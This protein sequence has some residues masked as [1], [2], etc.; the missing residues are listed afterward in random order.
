ML[1]WSP[2]IGASF[3]WFSFCFAVGGLQA[4]HLLPRHVLDMLDFIINDNN[5][6]PVFAQN[7]LT[8]IDITFVKE[9]IFGPLH[10]GSDKEGA[11]PYLGRGP[12]KFFLYEI[13]AN[14]ISQ[15]R[16][17]FQLQAFHPAL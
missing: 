4:R 12:D 15:H 16:D 11:W 17:H 6:V 9:M 13:V 5:L 1:L 3:L 14:K 10:Q 7:G 2:T 8:E